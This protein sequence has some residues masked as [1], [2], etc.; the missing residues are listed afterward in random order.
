MSVNESML[1]AQKQCVAEYKTAGKLLKEVK[2]LLPHS[3][4]ALKPCINAL[5]AGFEAW[6]ADPYAPISKEPPKIRFNADGTHTVERTENRLTPQGF[7]W[8]T[9]IW[10]KSTRTWK[11]KQRAREVLEA[12]AG[13]RLAMLRQ[14]KCCLSRELYAIAQAYHN[15]VAGNTPVLQKETP[16]VIPVAPGGMGDF[17]NGFF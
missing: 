3:N 11:E 2:K 9:N 5:I 6:C 8:M 17:L 13:N 16:V 7:I 1:S 10:M 14:A 15:H 4:P 12:R